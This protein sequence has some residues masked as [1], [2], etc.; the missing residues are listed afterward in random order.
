MRRRKT[1][2]FFAALAAAVGISAT[3]H[4]V[5]IVQISAQGSA[6][7]Q[8]A[9]HTLLSSLAGYST[10]TFE[11]FAAAPGL[12]SASYATSVGTF[13]RT[14]AGVGGACDNNGYSCGGG[15][16]VLN[17]SVTP[18][19]GRHAA[20][21]GAGNNN[22]LDSMDAE[23]MTFT[24]NA[25]TNVMGFYL[26]DVNDAGGRLSIG[27]I[28]FLLDNVLGSMFANGSAF[29]V[30]LFD[31]SGLGA[32]SFYSN[33]RADGYGIDNVTVAHVPEPD[34]FVLFGMGLLALGLTRA[35]RAR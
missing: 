11:S 22:W 3:A 16:A 25:G 26:T 34:N 9:E 18:F 13:T 7:A 6:N 31:A 17:D 29:Y 23:V 8:A 15:L 19:A 20:P 2:A 24:P 28:D 27:G 5:P 21:A 10:E 32:I 30:Q 1:T 4:A 12:Q 35:I 14:V 33:S